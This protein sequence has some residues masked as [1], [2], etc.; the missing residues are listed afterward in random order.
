MEYNHNIFV[1]IL[2]HISCAFV[3]ILN[4]FRLLFF[5]AN[6]I[7]TIYFLPVPAGYRGTFFRF[8]WPKMTDFAVA[9]LK[10]C[11]DICGISYCFAVKIYHRQ[12]SSNTVIH[13]L[14][15]RTIVGLQANI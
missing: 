12:H 5:I 3:F 14:I 9:F 13:F 4:V 10:I 2:S 7:E 11:S 8:L 1:I 6:T 15:S